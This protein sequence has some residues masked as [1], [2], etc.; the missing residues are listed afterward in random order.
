VA[1]ARDEQDEQDPREAALAR[2][3][4]LRERLAPEL[5]KLL[6]CA[7]HT[8]NKIPGVKHIAVPKKPGVYLFTEDGE[9]RYIGRSRNLNSR[10]GQHIQESAGENSAPFAFNIARRDALEAGFPVDGRTRKNLGTDPEFKKR[11]FMP[12]KRRV[13]GMDFR[14]VILDPEE[15]G[16]HTFSTVFE[17]YAAMVLGTDGDFNLFHTH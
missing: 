4:A 5:D 10:F 15:P 8:R 16:V 1:A 6:E 3:D 12:A 11:F 14:F 2:F 17:V 7:A 9:H 13:R